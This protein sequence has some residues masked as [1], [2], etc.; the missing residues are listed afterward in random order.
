MDDQSG[1]LIR[2]AGVLR[3]DHR[4]VHVPA[5]ETAWVFE[6]PE[7]GDGSYVVDLLDTESNVVSQASPQIEFRPPEDAGGG[8]WLADVLVYVPMHPG[9]RVLLFRRMLPNEL[10]IHRAELAARPP[11]VAKLVVEGEPRGE[12]RLSW[13]SEHDR[14]VTFNVFFW[15]DG[16]SPLLLAS[17]LAEH[18]LSVAGNGLPGPAGRFAVAASDGYRSSVAVGQPMAGF[19]VAVRIRI[20]APL[21][22]SVLPPDQPIDLVARAEDVSGTTTGVDEVTWLIDGETVAQGPVAA[23]PAPEP[24]GH[25]IQATG[26]RGT[27]PVE[28]DAVT[29]T[30]ANRGAA[31]EELSKRLAALPPLEERRRETGA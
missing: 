23:A 29:V 25:E 21:S 18:A 10:E 13:T 6:R 26:V 17:G 31:W 1:T 11:G 20:T 19:S 9:A 8:L 28:P 12:L 3:E 5:W 30:V 4:F 7:P 22:G 24:G 27:E 14:P 2:F 15:P 16:Q